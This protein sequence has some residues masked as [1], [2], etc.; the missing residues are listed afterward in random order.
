MG[1][2]LV[3]SH[4]KHVQIGRLNVRYLE[5]HQLK[6]WRQSQKLHS[7]LSGRNSGIKK[8]A[9]TLY[10]TAMVGGAGGEVS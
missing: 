9:D 1:Y 5:S 8:L 7:L 10:G 6:R 3:V 4:R 2:L